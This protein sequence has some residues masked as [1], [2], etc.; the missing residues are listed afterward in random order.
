[1]IGFL[2]AFCICAE[3]A[4]RPP[5]EVKFA[6]DRPA[7]NFFSFSLIDLLANYEEYF[8]VDHFASWVV[9]CTTQSSYSS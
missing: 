7:P 9:P 3:A 8:F 4:V 1:M 2:I 6:D 5:P